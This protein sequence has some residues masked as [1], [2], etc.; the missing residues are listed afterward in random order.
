MHEFL[1]D[2]L[3]TGNFGTY[4]DTIMEAL[5]RSHENIIERKSYRLGL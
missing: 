1:F 5:Q 2:S 3:A 4:I